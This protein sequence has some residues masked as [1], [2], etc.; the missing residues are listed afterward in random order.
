[1]G[2]HGMRMS[3]PVEM[4]FKDLYM[5]RSLS[6]AMSTTAS[7]Y[8]DL[9]G[10]PRYPDSGAYASVLPVP[11]DVSDLGEGPPD[12]TTPELPR[13]GELVSFCCKRLGFTLED[14]HGFRYRLRYPPIPTFAVMRH[15]LM[16]K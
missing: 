15:P 14:F 8:S 5:H 11:T 3:T 16:P 9:P 1:M 4:A 10:G 2:E 12:T 13:Y 7:V 6:F